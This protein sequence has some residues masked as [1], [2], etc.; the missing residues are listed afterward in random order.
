MVVGQS[1]P[2]AGGEGDDLFLLDGCHLGLEMG[3]PV[4]PLLGLG[5]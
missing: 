1:G 5:L 3:N 4:G 2:L